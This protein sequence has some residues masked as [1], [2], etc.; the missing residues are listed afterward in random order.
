M[1]PR[2]CNFCNLKIEKD[3]YSDHVYQ[4][5][6]RTKVCSYCGK[7][8]ILRDYET[9]ETS[10]I[11]ALSEQ[12]NQGLYQPPYHSEFPIKK[13]GSIHDKSSKPIPKEPQRQEIPAKEKDPYQKNPAANPMTYQKDPP[14]PSPYQ[15]NPVSNPTTYQ[16]DPIGP[17]NYQKD[18]GNYNKDYGKDYGNVKKEQP[19]NQLPPSNNPSNQVKRDIKKQDSFTY[20]DATKEATKDAVPYGKRD[21]KEY[22]D[23]DK[24]SIPVK[25][26]LP[27]GIQ[28]SNPYEIP[29]KESEKPKPASGYVPGKQY[30][31]YMQNKHWDKNKEKEPLYSQQALTGHNNNKPMSNP[32]Q[33][34]AYADAI[35]KGTTNTRD[36]G[37][38]QPPLNTKLQEDKEKKPNTPSTHN[39]YEK[40]QSLD[41]NPTKPHMK[42][43]DKEVPNKPNFNL[44]KKTEQPYDYN[45]PKM[46]ETKSAGLG[47]NLPSV[48]T[49]LNFKTFYF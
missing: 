28:K 45:K 48:V 16:K 44:N 10:C 17:I 40:K 23:Y 37:Y 46:P 3:K 21:S 35:A 26:N 34:N 27:S 9:H 5:S 33:N 20:K 43:Y 24:P 25:E 7:N 30:E 22:K 42:D 19:Y 32:S 14:G 15:K 29:K 47:Q 6:S 18:L 2:Q 8:V 39:F 13:S 31:N 1:K 41:M 36:Q 11:I 4:C 38:K 12:Q 49:F